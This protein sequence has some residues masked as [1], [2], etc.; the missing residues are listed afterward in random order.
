MRMF[1]MGVPSEWGV[2]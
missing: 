1:V 2:V